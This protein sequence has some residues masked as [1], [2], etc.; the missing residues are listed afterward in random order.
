MNKNTENSVQTTD[1]IQDEERQ[2]RLCTKTWT[3]KVSLVLKSE[4]KCYQY[5]EKSLEKKQKSSC[6][7]TDHIMS[8]TW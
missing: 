3:K 5:Y 2:I 1:N 8:Q 4:D 7:T 6:S